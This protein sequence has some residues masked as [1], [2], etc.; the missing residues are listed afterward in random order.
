MELFGIQI[1]DSVS[2]DSSQHLFETLR[3]WGIDGTRSTGMLNLSLVASSSDK[4]LVSPWSRSDTQEAA[5]VVSRVLGMA[6]IKPWTGGPRDEILIDVA[7]GAQEMDQWFED[8]AWAIFLWGANRYPKHPAW[9]FLFTPSQLLV[10]QTVLALTK[11]APTVGSFASQSLSLPLT[12]H[13]LSGVARMPTVN[14]PATAPRPR[15]GG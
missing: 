5:G 10:P 7:R 11:G 4:V 6:L 13:D 9:N 14:P 2:A 15:R 1:R 8:L 12:R 3:R